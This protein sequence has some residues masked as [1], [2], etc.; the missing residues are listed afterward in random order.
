MY[1]D[2]DAVNWSEETTPASHP[3]LQALLHENGFQEPASLISDED[4]LDPHLNPTEVRQVVDADA[5]QTLAILDVNQGQNLIIQ[6]PPGTGKSQ[7]I[8]NLISEA[9]GKG[10]T[11]LFVAEKMA[12]LEVVKRRLDK[13]GLGEAC[14]ELHSHKTNK[15][16][17]TKELAR[18]LDLGKPKVKEQESELNLLVQLRERLNSYCEAV[19]TPIGQSDLSTYDVYGELLQSQQQYKQVEL[20][21]F[22]LP[23]LLS[24]SRDAFRQRDALIQELQARLKQTGEPTKLL[25]WGSQRQQL[26]P[27]EENQIAQAFGAARQAITV[28]QPNA[29]QLAL[30]VMV[31][32]P[33]NR[34]ETTAL[35][36]LVNRL[37]RS[38]NYAGVTVKS[39]GWLH[40]QAEL[41]QLLT[42]GEAYATIQA[43]FQD[44]LLPAAWAATTEAMEVRENVMAFGE[45]WWKFLSGAYRRS[46]KKL[47]SW[48]KAVLPN[49]TQEQLKLVDAILEANRQQINPK[50]FLHR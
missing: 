42:A 6:G 17:V 28:L 19:N 47:A 39:S 16:E 18:T 34:T 26:L 5:S 8:T 9:I 41:E 49:S 23:T 40:Q 1:N 22:A 38:P 32:L 31:P 46:K 37:L 43:Q 20:P 11:V 35:S 45:K 4:Y 29:Q 7:T 21:R 2:L 44:K 33:T 14:L 12:A 25:F 27:A 15:K 30:V 10:K 3:L 36:T 13:V 50:Y 48:S 24:W